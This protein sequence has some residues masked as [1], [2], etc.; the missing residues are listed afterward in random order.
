M[1]GPLAVVLGSAPGRPGEASREKSRQVF[2]AVWARR[3]GW[4]PE[5]LK[6]WKP[7][8]QPSQTLAWRPSL[9][10]FQNF[11]FSPRGWAHWQANMWPT[12]RCQSSW[13]LRA[14]T[15]PEPR[16]TIR[17]KSISIQFAYSSLNCTLSGPLLAGFLSHFFNKLIN[18]INYYIR[19]INRRGH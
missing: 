10:G 1:T 11:R 18:I 7:E 8:K 16:A 4:E 14:R 13:P 5:K 17:S 3:R 12:C 2:G 15:L 9:P 19:R 6:T